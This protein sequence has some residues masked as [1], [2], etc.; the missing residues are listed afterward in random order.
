M[1][2]RK[3]DLWPCNAIPSISLYRRRKRHRLQN[4]VM[5]EYQ[6]PEHQE[7]QPGATPSTHQRTSQTGPK[8][9]S[10]K[11]KQA[12]NSTMKKANTTNQTFVLSTFSAFLNGE[13]KSLPRKNEGGGCKTAIRCL[14]CQLPIRA[15]KRPG[16]GS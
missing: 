5:G 15:P 16:L 1:S 10:K 13:P 9:Q 12:L 7:R 14:P 4:A 2:D 6:G 8:T 3:E 11:K